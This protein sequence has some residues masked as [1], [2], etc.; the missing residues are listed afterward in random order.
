MRS[1][2][3]WPGNRLILIVLLWASAAMLGCD[4]GP[5]PLWRSYTDRFIDPQGRVFD[6]SGDQQTTSEQQ[7][8][9]LFFALVANDQS[10]FHRVLGWTQAHLAQ[11]DLR[12]HLPASQWGKSKD[13]QE[14]ILDANSSSDADTWI[15]YSL[16]EAGRLWNSDADTQLGRALLDLIAKN[17]VADL[18]GFG[19][20]LLPSSTGFQHGNTWT[21]NPSYLPLFLFERFASVDPAGPWQKIARNIP[22]LLQESSRHGFAMDWIEYVPGDGFYPASNASASDQFNS[23][24]DTPRGSYDAIRVYL[25][26]GM[27]NSND[28][29]RAAILN[30]VPGMSAYLETHDAPPEVV[31]EDGIP[32]SKSGPIGFSAVMLEYLRAFPHLSRAT[33]RQLIRLSEEKQV[34]TGLYGNGKSYYDQCLALFATGFF[35]SR[36][37]IGARGELNVK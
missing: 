31:N 16:L 4:N 20:M 11:N 9:T 14:T 28:P 22:R 27:I 6:P 7:A 37:R 8:Y 34:E 24:A 36:F 3:S 17:E 32:E 15:A 35:D 5:W 21:L 12:A 18:P 13:G 26:A 1:S 19:P 2:T 29:E 33:A 30:A 10:T 25:W 23:G